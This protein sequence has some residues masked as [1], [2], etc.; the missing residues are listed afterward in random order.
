ML[1][2]LRILNLNLT[3]HLKFGILV[4]HWNIAKYFGAV[5]KW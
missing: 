5:A 2:D 1:M 4:T 3:D